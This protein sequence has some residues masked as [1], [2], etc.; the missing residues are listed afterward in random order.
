MCMGLRINAPYKS[1]KSKQQPKS[2]EHL[3]SGWTRS[4]FF[5]TFS[6]VKQRCFAFSTLQLLIKQIGNW[7]LHIEEL[8]VN[9]SV[10]FHALLTEESSVGIKR[11]FSSKTNVGF[12]FLDH[13]AKDMKLCL[14]HHFGKEVQ[15]GKR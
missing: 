10:P 1:G 9:E 11:Q 8:G 2:Q 13:S 7:H 15:L 6:I 12:D 3:W 5:I 14:Q 4:H